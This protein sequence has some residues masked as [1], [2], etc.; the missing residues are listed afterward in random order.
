MISFRFGIANRPQLG[1][2]MVMLF[3]VDADNNAATGAPGP[4]D[5][6]GSDYVFEL[7][8]GEIFLYRWDGTGFTRRFGDPSSV[9]LSF[10]YANGALTVRISA[11]E[12]GNT[13]RLRFYV[14]LI[15]GI[16]YDPVTQEPFCPSSP[17]P[18]DDAPGG[19]AGLYPY[20]VII[21]KPSLVVRKLATTPRAPTAGKRFTMKVT[22]ARSDTNAIIRN[23]RVTC[24]GRAGNVRLK[25]QVA[26]VVSGAV[27]CT[28]LIPANAK[29]K[30]FRGTATVRFEGLNATRSFSARIR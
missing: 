1:Q 28:W 4:E 13:R 14:L 18:S 3:Y 27:T 25:A 26:R 10:A 22:A 23:G 16:Q 21:A 9:T 24:V 12:L 7:L 30:T 15:G 5:P 11:S 17:C 8:R 20:Q 6:P 2:D 19:G 29:G